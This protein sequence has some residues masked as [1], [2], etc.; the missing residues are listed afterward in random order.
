MKKS[1]LLAAAAIAA[2]AGCSKVE[3][4]SVDEAPARISWNAVVGKHSTKAPVEGT[5]FSTGHSFKTFAFYNANGTTWPVD[6][7]LYIDNQEVNYYAAAVAP[8]VANSWHSETVNYWPRQGSL[9]F[10]SYS[11]ANKP[12]SFTGNLTCTAADGLK[13]VGYDV[14]ETGNKNSDFMVADI[15]DGQR[16]N[17]TSAAGAEKGVPT[18]FRHALTQIV[19]FYV[20]TKDN[21]KGAAGAAL[22]AGSKVI[23]VNSIKIFNAYSKGDYTMTNDAATRTEKWIN[24]SESQTYVYTPVAGKSE[25][26]N[27]TAAVLV[28]DQKIFLPQDFAASGYTYTG[29]S[30][31]EKS[32]ERQTP[33]YK[34]KVTAV[35]HIELKYT[36]KTYTDDT[37][38]SEEEVT[39]LIALH[40]I[41]NW[42]I[43]KKI[44]YKITIDLSSNIIYWAPTVVA[45]AEE[46]QTITI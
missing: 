11:F 38:Y 22:A 10:F 18:I 17:T 23:E 15:K 4:K 37:N 36:I 6:A 3:V 26:L 46:D 28:N 35:G 2:L 7:S 29:V 33:G 14:N 13:L 39:E 1:I 32:L 8:F 40:E 30:L 9:T 24:Q 44:T 21:Y 27:N 42:N 43:N 25:A 34:A 5:T 12:V 16:Q 41:G 45:W 31:L 19:G 20:E